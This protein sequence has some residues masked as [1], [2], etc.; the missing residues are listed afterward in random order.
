MLID[1]MWSNGAIILKFSTLGI[2]V[3]F[4]SEQAIYLE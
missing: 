2:R 3:P 1:S 4:N